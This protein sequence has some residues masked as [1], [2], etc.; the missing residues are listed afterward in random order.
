MGIAD[1]GARDWA[2]LM[3]GPSPVP[4]APSPNRPPTQRLASL[5]LPC[6]ARLGPRMRLQPACTLHT[7]AALCHP[8]RGERASCRPLYH[9]PRLPCACFA[10]AT[11]ALTSPLVRS[12]CWC[13][14]CW[15]WSRGSRQ[16]L[17]HRSQ[18]TLRSSCGTRTCPGASSALADHAH[19]PSRCATSPPALIQQ[20]GDIRQVGGDEGDEV[21]ALRGHSAG[22]TWKERMGLGSVATDGRCPGCSTG[23]TWGVGLCPHGLK[24]GLLLPAARG[25]ARAVARPLVSLLPTCG[26]PG[27]AV[28]NTVFCACMPFLCKLGIEAVR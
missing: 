4:F 17:A 10:R 13:C 25:G 21:M 12:I 22:G 28:I 5:W 16:L 9:D 6:H 11:G 26:C 7:R 23:G 20:P 15:S 19:S 27:V 2:E 14:A 8:C 3:S 24:E 1:Q 18:R